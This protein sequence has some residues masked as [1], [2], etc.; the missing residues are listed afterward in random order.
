MNSKPL[1]RQTSAKSGFSLKNPY[2]GWIAWTSATS[3]AAMI[4]SIFR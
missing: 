3:A 2:P 1:V 4:R